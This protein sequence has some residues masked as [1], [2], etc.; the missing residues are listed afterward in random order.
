MT[1]SLSWYSLDDICTAIFILSGINWRLFIV[2]SS[3]SWVWTWRHI[4]WGL[5]VGRLRNTSWWFRLLWTSTLVIWTLLL[6]CFFSLY[7]RTWVIQYSSNQITIETR[8]DVLAILIEK[9]N[10][11]TFCDCLFLLIFWL[12]CLF[13]PY[14]GVLMDHLVVGTGLGLLSLVLKWFITSTKGNGWKHETCLFAIIIAFLLASLAV[15]AFESPL[16]QRVVLLV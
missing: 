14:T 10:I 2:K 13:R 7:L 15:F 1:S 12:D 16:N 8:F 5:K 11:L 9:L 4:W 3:R 6:K